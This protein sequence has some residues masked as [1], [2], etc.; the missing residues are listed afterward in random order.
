VHTDPQGGSSHSHPLSQARAWAVAGA[1]IAKGIDSS[2]IVAKGWGSTRPLI[3]AKKIALMKTS[4]EKAA[5]YQIDRRV[6]LVILGT[7]NN[8]V[9]KIKN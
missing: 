9:L 4:L 6:E 2:R 5:A 3:P 1:L 7:V 8:Y